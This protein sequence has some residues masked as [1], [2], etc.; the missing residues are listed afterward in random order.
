MEAKR[1]K[2]MRSTSMA[3]TLH[4]LSL[5][6]TTVLSVAR[7]SRG[8]SQSRESDSHISEKSKG[9]RIYHILSFYVWQ[10]ST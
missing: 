8:V 4:K 1:M 10:F 6:Y 9:A 5:V 3:Y 7:R 2:H